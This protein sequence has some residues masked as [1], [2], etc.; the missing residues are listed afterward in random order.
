MTAHTA[1]ATANVLSRL[2]DAEARIALLGVLECR[3][4]LIGLQEWG[5]SRLRLLRETGGVRI[6]PRLTGRPIRL[7]GPSEYLWLVPPLGGCVVGVRQERFELLDARLRILSPPARAE[8]IDRL[9]SLRPP[10]IAVVGAFRDKESERV[11]SL[12]SF[13]LTAGVQLGGLYREDRPMLVA[14]H[15]LEVRNLN[16][17][18]HE[19]L[20][21]GRVVQAAGDSNFDGLRID[22]LTSAWEGRSNQPGTLGP[23]RQVDDVHGPG[24]ANDVMLLANASDHKAVIVRRVD[25]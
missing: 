7:H 15:R 2:H 22:G 20:E 17:L 21:L 19:E 13:H 11:V 14:R 12:I 8:K 18:V 9:L 4:D 3:P 1:V 25:G 23:H 16:R 10:R 5:L 24:P 6:L